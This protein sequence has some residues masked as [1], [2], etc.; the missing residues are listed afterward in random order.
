MHKYASLYSFEKE[1]NSENQDFDLGKGIE[2]DSE[3][4]VSTPE[5]YD[6]KYE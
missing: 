3:E 6:L 2:A 5:K 1:Q 4:T